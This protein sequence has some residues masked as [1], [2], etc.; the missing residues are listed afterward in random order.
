MPTWWCLCKN[1]WTV[2]F[3]ELLDWWTHLCAGKEVHPNS[4]GTETPVLGMLLNLACVSFH[5]AVHLYPLSYPWVLW[6]IFVNYWTWGG[7]RGTL[8]FFFFLSA[9]L[10]LW[11]LSSLTRDLTPGPR[12]WKHR[13]LTAGPPGNSLLGIWRN[14]GGV[15]MRVLWFSVWLLSGLTWIPRN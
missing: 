15:D 1:P 4:R 3:R 11:D 10:G 8:I 7:G 5:L 13:V 2:G 14:L 12:Q 9:P 6:A